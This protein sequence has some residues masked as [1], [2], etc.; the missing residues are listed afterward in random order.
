MVCTRQVIQSSWSWN[1]MDFSG[2]MALAANAQRATTQGQLAHH[3]GVIEVPSSGPRT[4]GQGRM[5]F[6]SPRNRRCRNCKKATTSS[7]SMKYTVLFFLFVIDQR[8]TMDGETMHFACPHRADA[9]AATV[10][11]G[12]LVTLQRGHVL[13]LPAC[14]ACP[15]IIQSFGAHRP[16]C[17][18][19]DSARA[20]PLN[21]IQNRQQPKTASPLI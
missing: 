11:S 12:V 14:N 9:G 19:P 4:Q 3:F 7:T 1:L 18:L 15:P 10:R 17:H 5:A 21:P 2:W 16:C 20:S 13:L 8:I 6:L